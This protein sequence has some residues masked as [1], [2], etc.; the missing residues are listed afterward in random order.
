M[1]VCII[2]LRVTV[3]CVQGYLPCRVYTADYNGTAARAGFKYLPP[4]G[5][6]LIQQHFYIIYLCIFINSILHYK[7]GW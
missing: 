6:I 3:I 4:L 5:T 2:N 1:I 7:S